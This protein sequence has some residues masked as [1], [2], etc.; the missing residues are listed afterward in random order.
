MGLGGPLGAGSCLAGARAVREDGE[1]VM[2]AF[3]RLR[4]GTRAGLWGSPGRLVIRCWPGAVVVRGDGA[5]A[6]QGEVLKLGFL[7]SPLRKV[8]SRNPTCSRFQTRGGGCFP[9][10]ALQLSPM[11]GPSWAQVST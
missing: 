6:D 10:V 3:A 4:V 11:P 7:T 5:G 1:T 8:P 2:R 9:A